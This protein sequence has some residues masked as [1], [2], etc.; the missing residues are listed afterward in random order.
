MEPFRKD[1]F[2]HKTKSSCIARPFLTLMKVQ[3]L[4][5][6]YI[7]GGVNH[8]VR[9]EALTLHRHEDQLQ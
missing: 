6:Q 4:E 9:R 8:R 2:E 1:E 5:A 3:G 7:A